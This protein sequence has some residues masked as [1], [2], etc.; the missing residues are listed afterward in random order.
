MATCKALGQEGGL[1]SSPRADAD[2]L[3]LTELGPLLE[4]GRERIGQTPG[5]VSKQTT[6]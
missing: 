2:D 3:E 6:F 5:C 1:T 4:T